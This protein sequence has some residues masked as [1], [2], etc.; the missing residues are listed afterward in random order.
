MAGE[1]SRRRLGRRL[2]ARRRRDGGGIAGGAGVVHGVRLPDDARVAGGRAV[3]QAHP[4][5]QRLTLYAHLAALQ[6]EHRGALLRRRRPAAAGFPGGGHWHRPGHELHLRPV[7]VTQGRPPRAVGG[8]VVLHRGDRAGHCDLLAHVAGG[9]HGVVTDGWRGR[10]CGHRRATLW[11]R[12]PSAAAVRHQ[13]EFRRERRDVSGRLRPRAVPHV[14]VQ[15]H[16]IHG[17]GG[18]C[19]GLAPGG[20][21]GGG[22]GGGGAAGGRLHRRQHHSA[23]HGAGRRGPGLPALD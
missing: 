3:A 14:A 20:H 17:F 16:G 11:E 5:V 1:V 6:L 10:H 7:N 12:K 15:L 8:A 4:R 21:R 22:H 19:R 18:G 13:Q 9:R 2:L 23:P